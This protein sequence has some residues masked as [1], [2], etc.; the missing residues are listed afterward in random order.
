MGERG[1]LDKF[2]KRRHLKNYDRRNISVDSGEI[3][4]PSKSRKQISCATKYDYSYIQF[5][6]CAKVQMVLENHSA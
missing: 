4:Q 2:M 6:F 3:G 5:G 1:P